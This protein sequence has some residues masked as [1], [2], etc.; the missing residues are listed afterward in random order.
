MRAQEEEQVEETPGGTQ[1][2]TALTTLIMVMA[3]LVHL[4]AK[5]MKL[6]HVRS[7]RDRNHCRSVSLGRW[8]ASYVLTG[9][10][11]MTKS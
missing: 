10:F 8:E 2:P 9:I 1:E 7:R 3:I 4:T 11:S 5:E 6:K